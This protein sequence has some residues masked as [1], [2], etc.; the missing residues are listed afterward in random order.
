MAVLLRLLLPFRL[1][2]FKPTTVLSSCHRPVPRM[3]P[4][5]SQVPRKASPTLWYQHRP[6][7][8]PE[9]V[10]RR[11]WRRAMPP[12]PHCFLF[13]GTVKQ[14]AQRRLARFPRNRW[15]CPLIRSRLLGHQ[16]LRARQ[17]N[18]FNLGQ[19]PCSIQAT[20]TRPLSRP[21][22]QVHLLRRRRLEYQ[23]V[24]V[25]GSRIRGPPRRSAA[26]RKRTV[27]KRRRCRHH[28][29]L[30]ARRPNP[31]RKPLLEVDHLCSV[32]GKHRSAPQPL[33]LLLLQQY[34]FPSPTIPPH[35]PRRNRLDPSLRPFQHLGPAI[36]RPP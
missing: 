30:V 12:H 2:E 9:E 11:P 22:R 1:A 14:P 23:V 31:V 27:L 4:L 10:V 3:Q 35:H 20:K 34:P 25:N 33:N 16:V 26:I 8:F 28:P 6:V 5:S 36:R 19:A 21:D 24:E 32:L 29:R 18:H 15:H 13:Q 7:T 17:V